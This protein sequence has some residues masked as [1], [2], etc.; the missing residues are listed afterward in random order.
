MTMRDLIHYLPTS[1]PMS[2]T[3]EGSQQENEAVTPQ[4]PEREL[5][6][7]NRAQKPEVQPDL[8][9]PDQVE[10]TAT[11]STAEA[12][13]DDEEG[14]AE[15][16]DTLMVPQVKVAEDGTLIIDEESLTVE[17]QRMKGPNTIQD[18]DP[19]FER[20]STTTYSS[21]RK[22]THTKPWSTEETDMFFLAISM[23]GTDFTMICQLFPHR[24]RSEIKNK[25]KKEERHNAWRIDKAFRER[26]RLD[27]E[28]F[29]KLLEKILEF[30]ESKKKLKSVSQK[31]QTPKKRKE[32]P[33]GEIH[34]LNIMLFHLF[35]YLST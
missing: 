25:F 19:I 18:R 22:G 10:T 35:I 29:T 12:Q 3:L 2:S 1:N 16:E 7:D 8:R 23:V 30:Q 21:F 33:K 27:L 15:D 6:P 11:T 9:S 31:K 28:Y 24:A 26:R 20:G 34:Y 32:K 13:E 14:E 17:V 4:S 5:S